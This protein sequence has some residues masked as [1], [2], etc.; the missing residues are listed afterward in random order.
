MSAASRKMV[1]S[2]TARTLGVRIETYQR[3]LQSMGQGIH[4]SMLDT[5]YL[6]G[7][8]LREDAGYAG[9]FDTG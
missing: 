3:V 5:P 9:I 4:S 7:L 6:L 1:A 2:F 8:L